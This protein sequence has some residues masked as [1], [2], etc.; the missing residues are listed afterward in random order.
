MAPPRRP[1]PKQ[2]K[3]TS[4]GSR[5]PPAVDI[6]RSSSSAGTCSTDCASIATTYSVHLSLFVLLRFGRRYKLA[7]NHCQSCRFG[8]NKC[9]SKCHRKRHRKR[10]R[11]R[12]TKRFLS[13]HIRSPTTNR[14]NRSSWQRCQQRCGKNASCG[15]ESCV[16]GAST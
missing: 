9:S 13:T 3:G 8:C 1:A 14:R 5:P 6:S 10:H 11:E 7:V 15:P 16:G 4:S 2:T 12:F